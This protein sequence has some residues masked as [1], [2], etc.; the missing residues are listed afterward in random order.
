MQEIRKVSIGNDYKNSMHYVVGQPVLGNYVI[1]V[2]QR[3][4]T[5]VIIW[6]EKDKEVLCWKEINN[7]TPMVLEFNIN[8]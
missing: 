6:I 2:I 7:H 3:V 1:H 8:F 4:E 5:G